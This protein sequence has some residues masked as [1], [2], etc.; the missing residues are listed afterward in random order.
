MVRAGGV[1]AKKARPRKETLLRKGAQAARW[2]PEAAMSALIAGVQSAPMQIA[3]CIGVLLCA[4][5]RGARH[6]AVARVRLGQ[7]K[8]LGAKDGALNAEYAR[9][10]A[11]AFALGAVAALIALGWRAAVITCGMCALCWLSVRFGARQALKEPPIALMRIRKRAGARLIFPERMRA[12]A[13]K[14]PL[15]LRMAARGAMFDKRRALLLF[16]CAALC[17]ALLVFACALPFAAYSLPARQAALPFSALP[18]E[19]LLLEGGQSA[20]IAVSE[21]AP[22]YGALVSQ[23][24]WEEY[25]LNIGDALEVE[26]NG[27]RYPVVVRRA[28]PEYAEWLLVVSPDYYNEIFITDFTGGDAPTGRDARDAL[29]SLALRVIYAAVCALAAALSLA[30]ACARL[31]DARAVETQSETACLRAMGAKR[32]DL[33]ACAAGDV[34]L[35]G[36]CGFALGVA[37]SAIIYESLA[38]ACETQVAMLGRELPAAGLL[39]GGALAFLLLL[40]CLIEPG[41][42]R[43][44]KLEE[45]A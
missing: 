22:L 27:K 23:K 38:R 28:M 6:A 21:D 45:N 36:A 4:L 31:A 43:V 18:R 15:T 7:F 35:T 42:A 20:A 44:R 12:L 14:A 13:R 39:T 2:L 24:L 32:R 10:M 8:A 1:R 5:S 11:C 40:Y 17:A 37:T 26:R 34:L 29:A 30:L 25:A 9:P 33:L 19:E 16:A 3:L 41:R